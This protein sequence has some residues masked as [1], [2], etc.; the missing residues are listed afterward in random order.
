MAQTES[1]GYE[2]DGNLN[3]HLSPEA[4]EELTAQLRGYEAPGIS[5][6]RRG[7]ITTPADDERLEDELGL[8]AGDLGD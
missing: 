6:E 8:A 2:P 3:G 5:I 7:R 1:F 4:R